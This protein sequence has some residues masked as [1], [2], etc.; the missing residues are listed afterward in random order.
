MMGRKAR[1]TRWR[2][3]NI[4]EFD[5]FF[6]IILGVEAGR[7]TC[8]RRTQHS[9]VYYVC[10]IECRAVYGYYRNEWSRTS[11]GD[12]SIIF[13]PIFGP[14]SRSFAITKR[15][16]NR[17]KANRQ[18]FIT[19]DPQFTFKFYQMKLFGKLNIFADTDGRSIRP[20]LHHGIFLNAIIR[21]GKNV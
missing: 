17:K 18:P 11:W 7:S 5:I 16:A 12:D 19:L 2:T 14:S 1:K 10:K 20:T 6:D 3:L 8:F 21:P 13:Q 9:P 4:G 15:I